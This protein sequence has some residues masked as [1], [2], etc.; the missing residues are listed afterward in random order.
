VGEG[1][2]CGKNE[3]EA[4]KRQ[5]THY[6][7]GGKMKQRVS[8]CWPDGARGRDQHPTNTS[9]GERERSGK[10][11]GQIQSEGLKHKG[12][13]RLHKE[14]RPGPQHSKEKRRCG[15]DNNLPKQKGMRKSR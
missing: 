4:R 1:R 15:G 5:K 8:R 11:G 10:N 14:K 3:F 9:L 7:G 13:K 2:H 12:G 6:R